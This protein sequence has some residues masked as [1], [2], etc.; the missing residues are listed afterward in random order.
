MTAWAGVAGKRIII[1]G[2]TN[3]IGL[4]AAERLAADGAALTVVARSE[5]R[6]RQA[7]GI[8]AARTPDRSSPDVVLADLSVQAEVRGLAAELERRYQRVD[9]LINNAGAIYRSRRFSADGIELTWAL[10]HLAP[11]LLT[12]LLLDLLRASTPARIITTASAAHYGATIPFGD[13][14]ADRS[15][16]NMGFTRYG[17][18][19]LANILFTTEL[20]RRLSGSDVTANC[21]HPG[22]VGTGFNSNNGGLMRVAMSISHLFARTPARGAET[23]LWLAES[24]EVSHVSGAYFFDRRQI[25]PSP[26]ARDP[27][28]ARRLWELSEV[29]TAASAP[30]PRLP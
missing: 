11:F 24:E 10:N 18:T 28:T 3:G 17:E 16:K 15:Y 5:Q 1:T 7:L 19:K 6:A 20:A 30:A 29:Q 21:F 13:L 12:T 23:M 22:F 4:A 2:A 27:E 26:A 9:V 8:I 14:N 25:R